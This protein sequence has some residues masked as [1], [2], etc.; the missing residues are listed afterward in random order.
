MAW[1]GS[2]EE[3]ERG[4]ELSLGLPG[5]FSGSPGQAGSEEEHKGSRRGAGAKGRSSDGFKARPPAAAPVVGWPPVRSFRRNIAS[6]SSK[7]PPA[8]PQP[9]HGGKAGSSGGG[10]SQ[11]QGLFVKINMDGVPI[12]R[13]VDLKAHGGYGKLADAVDHLFRG[14]LAGQSSCA[15][16]KNTAAITGLLD[17]SGEYTLVYEDDEG[18]QMLVGDVPWDM[19]VATAKRLRVLRSSDLNASSLRAAVS[20][21]R[22]ATES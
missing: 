21:K 19:F 11:K 4:L 3:E 10:G 15:G 7:P 8:E 2:R 9:R 13:K 17:G 6:S 14:L 5:Y 22:G 20:R 12:G 1:N 18:D 16:E